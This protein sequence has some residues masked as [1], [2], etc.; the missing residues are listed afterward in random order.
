MAVMILNAYKV[1]PLDALVSHVCMIAFHFTSRAEGRS[2][3]EA[4]EADELNSY[5]QAVVDSEVV[6][7]Q[8]NAPVIP[9]LESGGPQLTD[10]NRCIDDSC[11]INKIPPVECASSGAVSVELPIEI[12]PKRY[13]SG[14][15]CSVQ[16]ADE[17]VHEDSDRTSVP[18]TELQLGVPLPSSRS[19][20][21]SIGNGS[22]ARD[23]PVTP[24]EASSEQAAVCT[25]RFEV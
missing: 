14:S 1:V 20:L 13:E 2:S 19:S 9:C 16:L 24:I 21:S 6:S 3:C 4:V 7:R 18:I 10:S 25:P 23:V 15:E 12:L 17:G 11:G 5:K 22:V 8:V